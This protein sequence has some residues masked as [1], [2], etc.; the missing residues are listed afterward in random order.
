V[1]ESSAFADLEGLAPHRIWDG[2]VGRTVHAERVTMSLIELEPGAV[3][4]EHGHEQEQ[5]GLLLHGSMTF[6][7]GGETRELGP[8][9]TWCIP[10]NVPHSIAAGPEGAVAFEV[11]APIRDD[12][13]GHEKEEPR[14]PRWPPAA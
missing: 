13:H 7:V 12:W 2:V 9:G 5:V 8:G 14:P 3:V 6:C 10:G 11:F 1:A 4:P